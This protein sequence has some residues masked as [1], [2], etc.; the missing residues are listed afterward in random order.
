MKALKRTLIILVII[1][2]ALISFG[3]IF[4]QKTKFVENIL[5]EFKLEA[6]LS[7]TRNI[8]LVVSTAT[9]TIIYDKDGN[10]VEKEGE[11]TTKQEVPVN[12]TETLTEENYRL[13]KE[14]I[15]KRLNSI[16]A[17]D[18]NLNVKKAVDYYEIKQNEQNG[19]I[20]VKIPENSDTDMVLQYMAIKGT[21]NVVDEQNNVLMNNSDIKK[22]QVV[23][24]STD[25]G[26][27]VYLTIQFNK[28]GT[29]KLKD[30]SNTFIKTTDEEGKETT[31]KISIKIDNTTVLSTYFSEEISTGMIQLT[32]GTASSK[33]E[34]LRN[35]VQE[36]NNLATLLNT[37]NLPIAYT[38][39]ENRYILP[40]I[41]NETFFVPAI[42]VLSIMVIAV[43]FLII[44]Y[45][46]K[47][48]LGALSFTGYIAS[49]LIIIRLTNVVVSIEGMVGILISIAL[50]YVFIVYL[51]NGKKKE[52]Q[53]FT[54]K[55]GFINFLFVLI[56]IAVTTIIFSFIS[57][58]PIYSF[59]M[60]MF[61]GIVLIM[62]Y[63][64]I[65][66]KPLLF[67]K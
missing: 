23:Y 30:I 24:N 25:S 9:D 51:L 49:L 34:D 13:A 22:A 8:G 4:I 17:V 14:V 61:W 16:K 40:D 5:P 59:G 44:K 43:L 42:I 28:E 47:G 46:V 10:V 6:E 31:K 33:S 60:T 63:N 56:P 18:A 62:L 1:L 27:S 11:G 53:E 65:L 35:Y 38:V 64:V 3:G 7:G 52:E 58:I 57:W 19:N 66:T 41:S 21:F 67:T 39:D 2:L 32:F 15:E 37:G 54:Y 36:A 12:P 20:V 26:I 45:R 48:I 55:Q 50:N 29:Q